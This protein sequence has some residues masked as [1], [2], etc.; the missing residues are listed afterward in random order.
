MEIN[1]V[2]AMPNKNTFEIKPVKELITKYIS[3][4]DHSSDIYPY[5]SIDPFANKN[6]LAMITND[7]DTQYD[8]DYHEDA[9]D[10]LRMFK[11]KSVDLVLL[12]APYSPRQVSESYKK[13][14]RSVNMQTTQASFW[15]NIKKEIG[16]IT[17]EE[18]IV[19]SCGWNSGGIGKSNGFK[20]TEI[21]LV[22]HGGNHND[23]IIT[24]DIKCT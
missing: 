17:K 2:W 8:T 20:I 16:R 10:F 22:P 24:V 1:R 3:M 4:F 5:I 12:D 18:A 11:D 15:G 13:L 19:I 9:L 23:T 7:L 14:G 6:K 21:L